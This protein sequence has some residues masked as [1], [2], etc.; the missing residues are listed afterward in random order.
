MRLMNVLAEYPVDQILP[1]LNVPNEKG[2]INDKERIE[3]P[4]N[5]KVYRVKVNTLRLRCFTGAI[6]CAECNIVGA[7][8]R[9]ELD[10]TSNA[11]SPHFNMYA[12]KDDEYILMTQDHILPRSKGGK[13]H[14][15][16][17]QTMCYVC[18]ERKG[19]GERK[20]TE[21]P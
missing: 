19:N 5:G 8:F 1:L 9:L 10:P 18:N 4:V 20:V 6:H 17:L 7:V 13:D 2:H 14:L 16:N 11:S 12:K 21:A 3:I 15:N